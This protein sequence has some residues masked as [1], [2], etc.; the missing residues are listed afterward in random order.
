MKGRRGFGCGALSLWSVE[1][2]VGLQREEFV[3]LVVGDEVVE[4]AAGLREVGQVAERGDFFRQPMF[5]QVAAEAGPVVE[6]CLELKL[7][8]R[9]PSEE[10]PLLAR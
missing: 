4:Q 8:S 9:L 2:R 10:Q 7:L 3:K 6:R 5:E 1:Q